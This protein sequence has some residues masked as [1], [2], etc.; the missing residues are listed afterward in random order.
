M[1]I[2]DVVSPGIAWLIYPSKPLSEQIY[3][4]NQYSNNVMTEQ[5]ALS[6]PLSMGVAGVH[7]PASDYPSVLNFISKWWQTHLSSQ[8]PMMSRASGLCRDCAITPAAMAEL[9]AFAYQ[10]PNF[11][12]FKASLPIAG[13][14]GTMMSLSER[15]PEHPAIGRAHI[16]TGT[17]NNVKS[18]A[19]YVMDTQGRWYVFVGMINAPGVGYSD[20]ATAVMDEA[21]S[22]VAKL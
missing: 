22:Y 9:L 4:I 14:S 11:E 7:D 18:L 17:L 10:Q 6:L 1:R 3:L 16:K 5:V 15:D 21:L 8:P 12:V 20:H 13:Q 19:G 2:D